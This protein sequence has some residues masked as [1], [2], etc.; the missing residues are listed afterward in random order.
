MNTTRKVKER[1]VTEAELE[2]PFRSIAV[3]RTSL[4]FASFREAIPER[5]NKLFKR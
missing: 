1:L 3:L 4:A 5:A 2:V